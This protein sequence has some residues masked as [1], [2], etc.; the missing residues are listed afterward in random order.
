MTAQTTDKHRP[1]VKNIHFEHLDGLRFLCFL[2]VFL[3]HSFHTESTALQDAPL[4]RF[5]DEHIFGNGNMGSI[6]FLSL[7]AF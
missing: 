3:Y 6:S 4:Y 1:I 5:V 2:S 7:V